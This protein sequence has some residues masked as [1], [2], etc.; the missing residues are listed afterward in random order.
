MTKW[1]PRSQIEGSL[2]WVSRLTGGAIL[3]WPNIACEFDRR[4]LYVAENSRNGHLKNRVSRFSE[5]SRQFIDNQ[6]IKVERFT[7]LI[8]RQNIQL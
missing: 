4:Y 1:D 3:H 6:L 8:W 7:C 2:Y 5:W